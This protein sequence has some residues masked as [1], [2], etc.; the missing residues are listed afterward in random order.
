MT[1][2]ALSLSEGAAA[3]RPWTLPAA[4]EELG[5]AATRLWTPPAVGRLRP[6]ATRAIRP[7]ATTEGMAGILLRPAAIRVWTQRAVRIKITPLS[8]LTAPVTP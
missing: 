8:A 6:V 2:V 5:L 4:E 1:G 7:A 3:I